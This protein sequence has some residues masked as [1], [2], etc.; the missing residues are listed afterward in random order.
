MIPTR[1]ANRRRPVRRG[2]GPGGEGHSGLV[3]FEVETPREM[4][5]WRPFVQWFLAIPLAF[6]VAIYGIARIVV[7]VVGWFA[8]LFTGRLPVQCAKWITGY[9]RFEWRYL[10][11]SGF[12]REPYPSFSVQQ[13]Q[14]D[15][16]DDAAVAEYTLEPN[17]SRGLLLVKWLILIPHYLVLGILGIAVVIV[18]FVAAFTVLFTGEWPEGMRDFVIG[19]YRW[20]ERVHTYL[21]M[22]SDEYP[23]FSL[24]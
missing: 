1:E 2:G 4:A 5:R 9:D 19:V 20:R 23:P 18:H 13:G 17:L 7:A 15:P 22:L 24:D 10:S 3:R 21:F 14:A 11:Y 12:L 16:G 6:V 8:V